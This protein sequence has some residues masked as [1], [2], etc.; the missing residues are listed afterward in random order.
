MHT[1]GA[2]ITHTE[3]SDN[4]EIP[5][6]R[7]SRNLPGLQSQDVQPQNTRTGPARPAQLEDTFGDMLCTGC[8]PSAR[9]VRGSGSFIGKELGF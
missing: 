9:W 6:F 4:S 7:N 5:Q 3:N 1:D 2:D 8:G